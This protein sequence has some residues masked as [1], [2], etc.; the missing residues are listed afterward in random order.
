VSRNAASRWVA[1]PIA[2]YFLHFAIGALG[3]R[4]AIDDPMNLGFYWRRGWW[5]SL[6]D[7]GAF[8]SESYRPM[9]A[10][11]Y[12]PIYHFF[13][14]NPLPYRIAILSLVA[15]NIFLSYRIAMRLT[16]SVAAATLTAVLVTAHVSMTP[17]YY[18]TSQ[19]YDVLAFLFTALTLDLY[20]R[21]RE[22]GGPGF[23]QGALIVAVYVAALNSKEIAVA[24]AIWIAAY[25]LVL[26]K[27]PWKLTVPALLLALTLAWT[28]TRT[29]GPHSLSTGSG[30]RLEVSAHSLLR[31]A[32]A[33]VNDLFFTERFDT[34][35]KLI[36]A[37]M[38]GTALCVVARK[39][40]LWWAWIAAWASPLAVYFTAGPR[41]GASLYLPLL[42][43]ALWM[44]TAATVFLRRWPVREWS[45]VTLLAV[46]MV[47]PTLEGWNSRAG[48]LMREHRPVWS[49]LE[50]LRDLPARPAPHSTVLFLN[51]P[52]DDWD[53]WFMATLTWNDHTLDVQLANKVKPP[54]DP[55]AFNWVLAFDGD[56]LRVVRSPSGGP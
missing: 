10:L 8:W 44:S 38:L 40:A 39:R 49:A 31:N 14:M 30:Y 4:F 51:N 35:T 12:L 2:L 53:I 55:A 56:R 18:N 19:I 43:V 27:R 47:P 42:A 22:R 16:R 21:S 1:I 25:E 3:A 20:M 50:Q 54:P 7:L 6:A 36:V 28:M 13:G 32:E 26:Q 24:G 34:A 37:W 11:F 46:L 15:L 45:A 5:R 9:A 33:Y 23:A 41:V 29:L 52:F 48:W 17:I